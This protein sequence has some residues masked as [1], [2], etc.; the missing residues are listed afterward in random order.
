MNSFVY[1]KDKARCYLYNSHEQERNLVA[2]RDFTVCLSP[3][4]LGAY[5]SKPSGRRGACAW[6]SL[7]QWTH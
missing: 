6:R 2:I 4:V 3:E 7:G 5:E 1:L